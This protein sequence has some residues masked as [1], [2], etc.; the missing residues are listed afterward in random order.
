MGAQS[1]AN[2]API[3]YL[4]SVLYHKSKGDGSLK[5]TR[6]YEDNLRWLDPNDAK[7]KPTRDFYVIL[8]NG[9]IAESDDPMYLMDVICEYGFA[10]CRDYPTQLYMIAE[11]LKSESLN[12]AMSGV[13]A[14]LYDAQGLLY[15]PNS[16]T[17]EFANL[18]SPITLDAWD[19]QTA[20]MDLIRVGAIKVFEKV[21]WLTGEPHKGCEGCAFNHNGVCQEWWNGDVDLIQGTGYELACPFVTKATR[22]DDYVE[23]TPE[24]L[25]DVSLNKN[26]WTPIKDR[27]DDSAEAHRSWTDSMQ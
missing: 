15:D 13:Y 3:D 7:Q 6:R 1:K 20:V 17:V 8:S 19:A 11:R 16:P 10:D 5:T 4:V 18:D 23:A 9:A 24:R 22:Y 25:L 21:P 27:T 2:F 12:L 14:R 26:L